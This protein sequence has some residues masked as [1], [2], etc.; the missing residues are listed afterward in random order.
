MHKR[1]AAL[2]AIVLAAGS[3]VTL[4]HVA[5]EEKKPSAD[6]ALSTH[7]F[8]ASQQGKRVS[9]RL[10]GGE[11]LEGFVAKIGDHQVLLSNLTGR[12]Y[13]DALVKIESIEAVIFRAREAGAK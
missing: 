6:P 11:T 5:A 7:D 9:V 3:L 8:L 13:Y 1:A 10:G 4:R 12:D 2:A